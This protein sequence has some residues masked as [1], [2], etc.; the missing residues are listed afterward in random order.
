MITEELDEISKS[1]QTLNWAAMIDAALA[2]PD[3]GRHFSGDSSRTLAQVW[4][5]LRAEIYELVCTD[6]AKYARE[7]STLATTMK[8]AVA[9]LAAFLSKDYGY[10]AAAASSLA[11]VALLLP[12]QMLK[13]AWCSVAASTSAEASDRK[14][15]QQIIQAGAANL[16]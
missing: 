15:L 11:S 10:P 8:P 2:D 1:A 5:A 9:A 14:A 4:R 12:L 3:S 6:S 13:D 7:R 16:S